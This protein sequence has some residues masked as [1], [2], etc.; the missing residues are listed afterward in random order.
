MSKKIL[1]MAAAAA[2]L[3]SCGKSREKAFVEDIEA[4]RQEMSNAGLAVAV[5]K[6]NKIDINRMQRS[7][8]PTCNC[9]QN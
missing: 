5:V 2:V 1:L 4:F 7:K 8:K 6:D 9:K 3:F